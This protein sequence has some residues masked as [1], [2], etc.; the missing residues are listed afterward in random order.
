LGFGAAILSLIVG[1][2]YVRTVPMPEHCG[3]VNHEYQHMTLP[4][5]RRGVCELKK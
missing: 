4:L 1:G 3:Q 5:I 2:E